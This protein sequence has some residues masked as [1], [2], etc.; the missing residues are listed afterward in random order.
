MSDA[1][2]HADQSPPH[3]AGD[4]VAAGPHGE[5]CV[6]PNG[7]LSAPPMDPAAAMDPGGPSMLDP[8]VVEVA[9]PTPGSRPGES[10]SDFPHPSSPK[11]T[12]PSE[13]PSPVKRSG[14]PEN[15]HKLD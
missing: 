3:A 11:R 15:P 12:R 2:K 5:D 14:D 7:A 10:H 6:T 1:P 13:D 8:E 9:P 4:Q